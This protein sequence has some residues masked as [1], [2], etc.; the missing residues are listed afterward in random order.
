MWN[1]IFL[2][3][4]H[5]LLPPVKTRFWK[6]FWNLP[7]TEKKVTNVWGFRIRHVVKVW[8]VL[9]CY[10][11]HEPYQVVSH[12]FMDECIHN[13]N[14]FLSCAGCQ[15]FSS[16]LKVVRPSSIS[17]CKLGLKFRK[18]WGVSGPGNHTNQ[19]SLLQGGNPP[20]TVSQDPTWSTARSQVFFAT[21]SASGS[22]PWPLTEVS[23]PRWA[24][25]FGNNLKVPNMVLWPRN[26]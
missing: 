11:V 21:S 5:G 12:F 15:K 4:F 19:T 25:H 17:F 10:W 16:A 23:T 22:W 7:S 2:S 18:F 6:K 8:K 24:R 9:S 3:Y 13:N 1:V 26:D 20:N 14:R